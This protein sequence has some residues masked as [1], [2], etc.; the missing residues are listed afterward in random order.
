M[1]LPSRFCLDLHPLSNGHS[2]DPILGIRYNPGARFDHRGFARDLGLGLNGLS[3]R[4]R[5]HKLQL[6]RR[7]ADGFTVHTLMV[8]GQE[9]IAR[10]SLESWELKR[11]ADSYRYGRKFAERST[12]SQI[13]SSGLSLITDDGR[14]LS[15]L[16]SLFKSPLGP[17]AWSSSDKTLFLYNPLDLPEALAHPVRLL[18]QKIAEDLR[19]TKPL[20]D[21]IRSTGRILS[22]ESVPVEPS[23]H[24]SHPFGYKVSYDPHRSSSDSTAILR[25]LSREELEALA[26]GDHLDGSGIELKIRA[27]DFSMNLL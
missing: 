16:Q 21:R 26:R 15:V 6:D 17:S 7:E 2:S 13:N 1:P 5:S 23:E 8:P 19:Q 22:L 9:N 12:S 11:L 18:R 27:D 20:L 14:L 25:L 4:D 3:G 10:A 24:S